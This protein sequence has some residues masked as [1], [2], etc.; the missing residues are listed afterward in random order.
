MVY[1]GL[2]RFITFQTA[3][4][5]FNNLILRHNNI[6]L[7]LKYAH[8]ISCYLYYFRD[9]NKRPRGSKIAF[10]G[11]FSGLKAVYSGLQWFLRVFDIRI[12]FSDQK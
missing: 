7:S 6:F 10:L 3:F 4:A 8:T 11:N 5:T 12:V 1:A 9:K 2:W